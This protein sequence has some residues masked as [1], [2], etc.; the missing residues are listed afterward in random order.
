MQSPTKWSNPL[1]RA[2]VWFGQIF[3]ITAALWLAFLLRFDLVL[4]SIYVGVALL[5]TP[6]WIVAKFVVFRIFGLDRGP[7]FHVSSMDAVILLAANLVASAVTFSCVQL[8][9]ISGFPRSI[10]IL[11]GVLCFLLL[12]GMRVAVK[13]ARER[14][15]VFRKADGILKKR[16]LIYGA[17]QAGLMLIQ[18]VWRNDSLPYHVVGFVD[19]A[20]DK[21]GL[22]IAGISVLGRGDD[23][24]NIV[25]RHRVDVVLV[26]IPS[27]RGE[28]MSWIL[29]KCHESEVECKTV[30][31]LAEVILSRGLANQMRDVAVEDLL[32]R[33][34]VTLDTE[35]I[36]GFIEDQTVLVTGAGGSIGSELCRQIARFG[37]ARIIGFEMGESA[38]F[39]IDR[40]MRQ[41]FPEVEFCPEIGDI[42]DRDRLDE[43]FSRFRPSAVFHAA[44]YKH[45]P[46]MEMHPFEAVENNILGSYNLGRAAVKARVKNFVLIST[47]KAVNPT[48]VMGATKRITE[49]L[50]LGME[51]PTK[52]VAVRFGNVLGS[53][54]SVIP[55]FK[56]QIAA[57]GPVTVTHPEMKRFFMTIP[58]ACQLVLQAATVAGSGQICVLDMGEPV[59]IVDLARNLILLS[60]LT[61]DKDVRIEFTGVRPGE[62]LNEELNSDLEHCRPSSHE[63]ITLYE[64]IGTLLQDPD[65]WLREIHEI[66]RARDAGRLLIAFKELVPDY[67]PSQQLLKWAISAG[68]VR[69]REPNRH[70]VAVSQ[71]EEATDGL[72]ESVGF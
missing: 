28:Q 5:A 69:A 33:L 49:L 7:W 36:S 19:D 44:A 46:L 41:C 67:N 42:R 50:L 8:G 6:I 12:A 20:P 31:G 15:R 48:N 22:R 68:P 38:L 3:M 64:G 58:E 9:G 53:N 17:G 25:R 57:G 30:P 23:L 26:A 37:P 47:D 13:L 1:R 52:F 54:G 40:Q 10:F 66:C 60:G 29:E 21:K 45:V 65:L 27:A 55:V 4:P 70:P 71:I 14:N 59:K 62:K 16:T 63:K 11:D 24:S 72:V 18:E 35:R 61:P 43:V 2:L 51:S 32:G 34:P 39:E 56:Q